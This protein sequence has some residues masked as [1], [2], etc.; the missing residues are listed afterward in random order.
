M[1]IAMLTTWNTMCGI[2]QNTKFLVDALMERGHQV[3]VICQREPNAEVPN[4]YAHVESKGVVQPHP[5]WAWYGRDNEVWVDEEAVEKIA[6]CDVAHIQYESFL[7]HESYL[8]KLLSKFDGPVVITHHSSCIGPNCPVGKADANLV[9]SEGYKLPRLRVIPMGIPEGYPLAKWEETYPQLGSFGL[10]RN[11][12]EYCKRAMT[13]ASEMVED[14]IQ[15]RTHYG[16]SKWVSMDELQKELRQSRILALIYP[17]TDA[18]VSSSAGCVALA[19]GL[20]VLCSNTKWF[21]HLKDYVHLVDNEQEMGHII[22][23]YMVEKTYWDEAQHRAK[24]AIAERGW[25]KIAQKHEDLYK[26][27]ISG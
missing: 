24:K 2:A 12:D 4:W 14:P 7:W 18:I 22:A 20:P 9:H 19:T 21:E 25:S 16:N 8:L 1:K 17:R 15:Y 10:H 11:D 23:H 6:K 27:L 5:S 26:E 13:L 3:E